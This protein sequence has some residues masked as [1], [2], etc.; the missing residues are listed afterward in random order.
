M[1]D[2]TIGL[3]GAKRCGYAFLCI[4]VHKIKEERIDLRI[5]DHNTKGRKI[6]NAEKMYTEIPEWCPLEDAEENKL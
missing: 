3:T 1:S 4:P 5:Y 2:R 6:D